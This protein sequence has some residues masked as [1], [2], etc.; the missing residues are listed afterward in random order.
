MRVPTVALALL[1]TACVST[2][3][4][5]GVTGVADRLYCGLEQDGRDIADADIQRFI[6]EV[7]ETRFAEGFTIWTAEGR[8]RGG[9]AGDDGKERTL[10]IEIVHPYGHQFDTRVREIADEYRRRFAQQSVM[11]VTTPAVME[12]VSR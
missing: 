1:L 11:R 12:F 8:W 10:V 4:R 2:D 5:I 6:A 7:V 9:G 3:P